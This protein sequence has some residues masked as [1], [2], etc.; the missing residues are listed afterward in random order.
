MADELNIPTHRWYQKRNHIALAKEDFSRQFI[1]DSGIQKIDAWINSQPWGDVYI[2]NRLSPPLVLDFIEDYYRTGGSASTFDDALNFSR[3]GNATMLDSDGLVKWAPH[4]IFLNSLEPGSVFAAFGG[5]S[6]VDSVA[7]VNPDGDVN[8]VSSITSSDGTTVRQG[9]QAS[10]TLVLGADYTYSVWVERGNAQWVRLL[11]RNESSLTQA[12][13]FDLTNAL[14]GTSEHSDARITVAGNGYYLLEVDYNSGATDV[15]SALTNIEPTNGNELSVYTGDNEVALYLWG[16]HLY[17]SDLGGMVDNPAT[18]NSYVPTTDS[19]RYLPRVGNHVYN[20]SDWVNEGLLLESEARTNLITHSS[21]YASGDWAKVNFTPPVADAIGPDGETSATTM[22]AG[23]VGGSSTTYFGSIVTVATSTDYTFSFYLK[24]GTLDFA[25]LFLAGFTTPANDGYFFNLA[26]GSVLSPLN[27]G[28][29]ITPNIEDVGGGWHRCSLT[30]TTDAADTAAEVRIYLSEGDG[31]FQVAQDGTSSILIY[32]AQFEEGS[33]PSS[34][35]PTAGSTVTRAAETLDV[36]AADM[37]AYTTAVSIQ[38]DGAMTYADDDS[39]FRPVSWTMD[40]SNYIDFIVDW[41]NSLDGRQRFLQF[42]SGVGDFV[43][44]DTAYSPG[45]NVPFSIASRHGS[46]FINGAEGGTAFTAN[47]TPTA[48]PDLSTTDF[49]IG[50]TFMG[51]LGKLRVWAE[52]LTDE[53]L[54]ESTS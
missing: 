31:D 36:A 38:M 48:L 16:T 21:S 22:T 34:Y 37:P 54:E 32:G 51:N 8:G 9:A 41:R 35:I 12:T 44:D 49:D 18:G 1:Y 29:G 42:A 7:R 33:T 45:I 15:T 43:Q 24:S 28:T 47:T 19:A 3:A 17:R 10:T 39:F 53:G 40:T 46:T 50:P 14:I 20:G 4:N 25:M 5:S 27:A 11:T 13:W 26:T 23:S 30:F 6:I 52:D 2:V